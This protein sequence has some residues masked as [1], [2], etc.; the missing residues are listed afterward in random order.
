[1]FPKLYTMWRHLKQGERSNGGL[2]EVQECGSHEFSEF[3]NKIEVVLM[4]MVLGY[5]VATTWH[6][7]FSVGGLL[8]LK[9][10]LG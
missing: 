2:R 1:M 9:M 4:K 6:H 5:K 7:F 10:A 8:P 3:Q